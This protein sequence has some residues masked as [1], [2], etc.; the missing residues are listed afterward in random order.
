[1][2]KIMITKLIES[3]IETELQR[4]YAEKSE[5]E[6]EKDIPQTSQMDVQTIANTMDD[7]LY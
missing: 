1:M 7:E 2:Q 3:I 4:M 5:D 6:V